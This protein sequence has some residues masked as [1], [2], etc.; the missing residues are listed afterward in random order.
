M[1]W[2]LGPDMS[3]LFDFGMFWPGPALVPDGRSRS[4]WLPRTRETPNVSFVANRG[5]RAT[6]RRHMGEPVRMTPP[7]TSPGPALTEHGRDPVVDGVTAI[8][9]TRGDS[10][11][12]PSSLKADEESGS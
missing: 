6:A 4:C 10:V 1:P 5:K 8:A 3:V 12:A 2:D 9:Q 11:V 7:M